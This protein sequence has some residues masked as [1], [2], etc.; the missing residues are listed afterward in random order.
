MPKRRKHDSAFKFK[1]VMQIPTGEPVRPGSQPP[2]P[3]PRTASCTPGRRS[4]LERGPQVFGASDTALKQS[5]DK[6]AALERKVG[7][8]DDATMTS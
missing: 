8:T 1:V 7:A 5:E 4:K 6:V 3:R 2:V